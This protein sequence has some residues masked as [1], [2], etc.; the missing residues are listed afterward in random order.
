MATEKRNLRP[1]QYEQYPDDRLFTEEYANNVFF[2]PSAW[3]LKLI[4]G[5]L[6]QQ[7]GKNL[8]RQ[9]TAMTLSWPQIKIL[10]F[11]LRGYVEFHEHLN[12]LI[13]VPENGIPP[14]VTPPTADQKDADPSVEKAYEIFKRLRAEL[15]ASQ[16][17]K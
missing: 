6:D 5:Q 10:S 13:Q 3:D 12:G 2:E 15:L 14:E 4:F 1:I 16:P 9:H 8:I 11:W 7:Q 17:K